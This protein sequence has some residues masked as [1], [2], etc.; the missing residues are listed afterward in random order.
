MIKLTHIFPFYL[1]IIFMLLDSCTNQNKDAEN[2]LNAAKTA[3]ENG[4]YDEAK[5][6]IDSIKVLFPKAFDEIKQS[7]E[8]LHDV[9]YAENVKNI[10][11]CDSALTSGEQ[12]LKDL[13]SQFHFY[14][15]QY[16]D[17]GMYIPNIY[18][19]DKAL[20]SNSLRSAVEETGDMFIESVFSNR[21]IN[22]NQL[23]ITRNDTTFV[24]TKKVTSDGLNYQVG[25][26]EIVRFTAKDE[27]GLA[28][29]IYSFQ[30][31]PLTLTFIGFKSVNTQMSTSSKKGIGKS[32]ELFNLMKLMNELTIEKQKSIALIDYLETKIDKVNN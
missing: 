12:K 28:Q 17:Y 7:I 2:Y 24:E 6:K 8:L 22:H 4:Y 27:N 26:H 18:P 11:Y 10:A 23:K 14:K 5:L 1:F 30:N 21:S 25:N 9:R 16:M 3:Y 29:F 32:Y 20:G 13:K 31:E 15:D 19:F